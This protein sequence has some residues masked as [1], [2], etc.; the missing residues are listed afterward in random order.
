MRFWLDL[1]LDGFRCDAAPHLFEREGTTS[2][3]LPET[4]AYFKELRRELDGAY[5][6]RVL[7]AEANQGPADLCTYF[8]DGDE[9]HL[10]FHF[11]L[12]PRLFLA[13]RREERRS[14]VDILNQTLPIPHTCQWLTF[15]RNHDEMTLARVTD[16]E[17]EYLFRE[18]AR[19]PRMRLNNGI[20]RRLAP[21]VENDRRQLELLYSLVLTLP[22]SPVF[23]YG[24][25]IGMG[26]NIWLDDRNGL[27]TPMQWSADRNA[28]FSRANPE[29]LY[30]PVILDPVYSYQVI[31]VEAQLRTETSVLHWLRRLITV[32]K[33]HSAFGRGTI[34][35][36][37]ASDQRILAYVR[38]YRE[39]T[40]LV[41]N[42]L[43]RS[44]LSV[45][46]DLQQFCGAT[47]I[48]LIGNTEFPRIGERPY[49]L[50]LGPRGFYWFR[51]VGRAGT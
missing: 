37:D 5:P 48:E 31:N 40:L 4:H 26:D 14:I 27:R 28:G 18:Y 33:Q 22:G 8:G 10:A 34:E 12:M 23:Y 42:N 11:P 17:R 9:F 24:D 43:S 38:Q 20:R 7:L 44:I 35:F 2:E 3:N 13:L 41:V 36:L 46:L 30:L 51:L 15:L 1:G 29:Q 32:R 16:E 47:P 21:L 50:S 19:E 45:T 25:E 6:G 49:C 39:E